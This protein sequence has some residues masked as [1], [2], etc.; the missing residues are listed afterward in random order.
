MLFHPHIAPLLTS[1]LSNPLG[2]TVI[3]KEILQLLREHNIWVCVNVLLID[4]LCSS[5]NLQPLVHFFKVAD[6]QLRHFASAPRATPLQYHSAI[7]P[8]QPHPRLIR[9]AA[10]EDTISSE[11]I[12]TLIILSQLGREG[13][14]LN[15]LSPSPSPSPADCQHAME[16]LY[17]SLL[18]APDPAANHG[19]LD[20]LPSSPR[21]PGAYGTLQIR[22]ATKVK[23]CHHS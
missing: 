2:H 13:K 20:A 12:T 8:E 7:P 14:V 5:I 19:L 18:S 15:W 9:A 4:C 10:K 3:R 17:R 11:Q 16:E 23:L 21:K 22:E 1:L 6:H